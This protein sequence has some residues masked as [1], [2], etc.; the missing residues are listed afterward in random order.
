MS[1]NSKDEDQQLEILEISSVL[2]TSQQVVEPQHTEKSAKLLKANQPDVEQQQIDNSGAFEHH[3]N[4]PRRSV[5]SRKLTEKGK[6]L[7]MAK[8]KSL[9]LHFNN[10][11]DC[12]KVLTKVA[13]RSL[14]QNHPSDILQE[15][16]TRI[17]KELDELNNIY[18]VYRKLD[19]PTHD[20]RCKLDKSTSITKVMIKNVTSR[21]Q[22]VDEELF[23]PDAGSVFASS[24]SSISFPVNKSCGTKSICSN[25]SL[26]KR[27]EAAAEYASTRAVLQ[28]MSEQERKQE[29]LE[30]LEVENRQIAAAQEA[31]A[32]SRRLQEEREEV[33]RKIKRQAQEDVL[34]RKQQEENAI[35]RQSVEHL[36][37][38]LDR[39]EGL[40]RLNA[41]KAKLQVYEE[42]NFD[43]NQDLLIQKSDAPMI[44]HAAKQTDPVC[45]LQLRYTP[46]RGNFSDD[47]QE[48]V[49]VLAEA[50][51]AN[52]LPVPE[53]T[54]FCGDPLKFNH[55]KLSF[56][57]LIERKN[58]PDIEKIFFLQRYVGGTA[59]EALEGH[60]LLESE[61]SY[62]LAWNLL[63]ERYGQP[64]VIAKA[65]RD[66][67]YAWP[68]ISSRDSVALRQYADFLRSCECA[69]S[70]NE[71]LHVLNDPTENQKL[72]AKL[73]ECLSQRW[74]RRATL[75]QLEHGRFPNFNY[76]VTFLS[77]EASIACNPITSHQAIWASEPENL[78][79]KN[80]SAAVSKTW[81]VDAKSFSTNISESWVSCMFCKNTAHSL[82]K[83]HKFLERPVADRVKFI[84]HEH[85]CFGCLNPGH[86]SKSCKRRL[87][88]DSC[89]RR[90]PT[91]LHED[92]SER[93][94]KQNQVSYQE[95]PTSQDIIAETTSNRILKD[96][97][98][99]QT[100]AIVPVMVSSNSGK[101]VLVYALLD[102]QS[103]SSFILEHVADTLK[104]NTES[105]KLKLST[106]SSRETIVPCKRLEGLKIR[107]LNS[108][109]E[110][111]V[112]TVYTREFIP[113]NRSHIPTPET[114]KAWPHLEHLAP[115]IAP[116]RECEIGLLI[117]YNCP[118][119]L[120]PREVVCG[121][122]NQPFAQKTDLGW[123]IVSYGNP[124]EHYGDAHAV[125]H[126]IIVRQVIPQLEVLD[127]LKGEVHFVSKT[128][129]K[130]MVATDD[131]MK[132]ESDFNERAEEDCFSQ[133]D[134]LTKLKDEIK[135]TSDGH[136]VM[137]LPFKS[138]R[139]NLLS[140]L[141]TG[142]DFLWKSQLLVGDDK[143]GEVTD[144][145][146]RKAVQALS[147]K[148][149]EERIL[150]NHL[151]KFSDW[152]RVVKAVACL[153]RYAKH[154]S[155]CKSDLS[156]ATSIEE[157]REA[158]VFIIKMVQMDAFSTEME[159]IKR[160]CKVKTKDKANKL[161]QLSAFIDE[162]GVFRVGGRL[163]RFTFHPYIK[164]PA[165]TPKKFQNHE[166]LKDYGCEF[167]MNIPS[168]SH[169]GGVW[170]RQIRT[171]RS[172]LTA[173]FDQ[174][175]KR[176]DSASLRT[177]LYEV[178]TIIN[179]RPMTTEHLNDPTSFEL[180][181]PNHILIM[182]SSIVLPPT[183]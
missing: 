146:E 12:W 17:E 48:L 152:E 135:H 155:G 168:S 142:S 178:T 86:Q 118:Q 116:Q 46:P 32:V 30:A 136:V 166:Q 88:C 163:A 93:E 122:E 90:H 10:A 162:H 126:R 34:L 147:N 172:V 151:A 39:L 3:Q 117:G 9:L 114:A 56:Q 174:S 63:D 8:L 182:K 145:S 101:E 72:V 54:I 140:N 109:K 159:S 61:D 65:F 66:Q 154:S 71:N 104:I 165:I 26:V 87:I 111:T 15:H 74:N 161:R 62:S 47:T 176:L 132:M 173:I 113:A 149:T 119:A 180:L 127:Q 68:C 175:G 78:R 92:R 21:I 95:D 36:R 75:Y 134:V 77:M 89:S 31:A 55:W 164:H 5:R 91:C 29:E 129:I 25:E 69:M 41:A 110:I 141:F 169:M 64:F 133:E 167:I 82:Q 40:K 57:T 51:A 128:Q 181:M 183:P 124:G 102:S 98:S 107:G 137:P 58:I 18:D 53:P 2:E 79:L 70:R 52:R 13:K 179:S 144:D 139:S 7:H 148:V 45:D 85:L 158:E 115:H 50:I 42:I 83:C 153:I 160:N 27:Q 103:D 38:E 73:P 94:S 60:F 43:T 16:V 108:T 96:G 6:D 23:W 143:V 35:R 125:S 112:P 150:L 130:E 177:F 11:Y 156:C 80:Q 123:S 131:V 67:L 120:M 59:K 81:T 76:F 105:V 22:G 157:R 84:Q 14:E 171:I 19:V 20:M 99:I 100:S 121:E 33:E 4:E 49:K 24:A 97:G 37:R 170:E 1:Q 106:M 138:E 44:V 28:I